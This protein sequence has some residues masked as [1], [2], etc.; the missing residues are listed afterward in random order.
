MRAATRSERH[1]KQKRDS[2]REQEAHEGS[3]Q[4]LEKGHNENLDNEVRVDDSDSGA[5]FLS[6]WL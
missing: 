6:R 1:V 5:Y 3:E 4:Q 2:K